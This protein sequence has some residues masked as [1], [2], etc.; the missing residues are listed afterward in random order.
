MSVVLVSGLDLFLTRAT[1][2]QTFD[3][4]TDEFHYYPLLLTL[5]ALLVGTFVSGRWARAA[6]LRQRWR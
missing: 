3:S 5:V 2:S 6:S 4:L 1:P